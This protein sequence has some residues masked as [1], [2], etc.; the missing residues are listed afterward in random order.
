MRHS[1]C[2]KVILFI[3]TLLIIG[4]FLNIV[5]FHKIWGQKS[6]HNAYN[7]NIVFDEQKMHLNGNQTIS[8]TNN[9]K[10]ALNNLYFHLYPNA[11]KDKDKIPIPKD[12]FSTAYPRGFSPGFIDIQEVQVD[13]IPVD[14]DIEGEQE[15]ILKVKLNK[16]LKP[17]KSIDIF[18]KYI[19]QLPPCENRF[20]YGENSINITNWYPILCVYDETGWNLDP[21]YSIGDPFYSDVSNYIVNLTVPQQYVIAHT[22]KVMD[23]VK[24][25]DKIQYTIQAEKVRDFA[26]FASKKY[27]IIENVVD[28]TTIKSYSYSKNGIK[29][30]EVATKALKIF[31]KLFGKYPY[32]TL[33]IAESDFYVGGME[34]PQIVQIDHTA[35]NGDEIWLEYLIAHEIAHQWWYGVIGNDE[36]EEPWL[37][38][39]LT[40][41]STILYFEKNY[42][43]KQKNKIM[44]AFIKSNIERH[45]VNGEIKEI[46][47]RPLNE[48]KNWQEYSANVYSKGAMVH[49]ELRNLIGDQKYFK[50]LNHYYERYKF[51]NAKI[52]DFIK[53]VSKFANKDLEYYFKK[54]FLLIE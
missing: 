39:G 25:H 28:G 32:D 27:E 6:I 17:G 2:R 13:N 47:N 8:Y 26:W 34:Y 43:I 11:F 30:L 31:N 22:G 4:I 10:V 29:A 36:I 14:Y 48:F 54:E 18:L 44:N 37:D 41:Y 7:I 9:E 12:E 52:K 51:Q 23:I 5:F 42:G 3:G 24:T 38:E 19:V 35:Y 50:L 46:I 16:K 20:G 1:T 45:K 49:H 15:T 21:Y 53:L 40:E 33:S